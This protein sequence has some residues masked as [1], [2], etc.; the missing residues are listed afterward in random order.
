MKR[1]GSLLVCIL[2]IG[3]LAWGQAAGDE[4]GI[5]SSE[6]QSAIFVK[7]M[8]SEISLDGKLD[9]AVWFESRPAQD[10]WEY[11]PSDSTRSKVGTQIYMLFD[12]ENLYIGAICESVGDDYVI[13]SLRRD[14]RAGGN[15]NLTFLI[16]PFQDRTNAFVF[17]M[18]PVG[19]RRE[20]LIANG[21]RGTDDWNG[22]WDNKWQG[23]SY[24]GDGFWSCELK[25]PLSTIRYKEGIKDWYFNSYRFDTQSNTRSTWTRI[26]QNQ[27]IMSLAYMGKMEWEEP[28]VSQGPS[29]SLIPYVSGRFARDYEAGTPSD[30][31]ANIGG[32][33]KITVTP[34]M[35]LDLTVNPDFSQVEVDQQ[36][37]NTDRFEILFPERRQFFLENADLF[38]TF[39]DENINP[40]FSRRIGIGQDTA[41]NNIQVPITYGARLSGKLDK[42][43]RLGLLNMQTLKDRETQRPNV[44]YTVAALQRK[45]FSRSN[46]GFIFVNK[47]S[48]TR[49]EEIN[50]ASAYNRIVGLDY[51]L[52][53]SDNRWLGKAFYHQAITDD[54]EHKG[55][56]K[57]A[58]GARIAFIDRDY[59]F[60]IDQQWVRGGYNPEVGFLRRTDYFR[61]NPTAQLFFYPKSDK[62]TRHNLQAD[63]TYFWKPLYGKTDHEW[64][65]NWETN[66]ANTAEL[67]LSMSNQFTYLFD[68]F[69]PTRTGARELP[70]DTDYTYTD[71]SMNYQS[72]QRKKFFYNINLRGGEFFNGN[73][74]SVRSGLTY[75]YQPYGSIEMNVNYTYVDLPAPYA[76]SGLFLIGPRI[77]L[78]FSKSLFWTTFIQYNSQVENLNINTRLQW[79]FAPVSDFFLVYTDN[80]D[81]FDFGVK[82]RALVAKV[83]YWLNL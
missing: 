71:F 72:D 56:E 25:I 39:G 19:V 74:Y 33:A 54:E 46:L 61:I 70:A 10:F 11:F 28:P 57:Y 43:W 7:R 50:V 81:T 65:L 8:D 34:S 53:S 35:N 12:E 14:F 73:R 29:I 82:N 6:V 24:I 69:D 47:E 58:Q 37:I 62:I 30:Y 68:S 59:G 20:A 75:R 32:D 13:S 77:D 83:T 60:G 67:R 41:G 26:P 16:D 66:F 15:D 23:E 76:S 9:E 2:L 42:N 4:E 78:T 3:Q 38:S 80:Y 79:R 40:F 1:I 27:I 49:D 36:V 22:G 44:N 45:V 17:G 52:A 63:V 51:N 21:G 55:Y 64:Q 5:N 48:F 18:N 31:G